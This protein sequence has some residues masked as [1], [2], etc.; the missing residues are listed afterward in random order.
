MLCA[1][2]KENLRMTSS[3]QITDTGWIKLNLNT[4]KKQIYDMSEKHKR[5][6]NLFQKPIY[7]YF[8]SNT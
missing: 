2:K 8:G 3:L 1:T 6:I 7:D 4:H 5:E